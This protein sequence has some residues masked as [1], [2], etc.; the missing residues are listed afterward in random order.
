[1]TR[2]ES[3]WSVLH[4]RN[5][6]QVLQQTTTSR[7]RCAYSGMQDVARACRSSSM[8]LSC[9]PFRTASQESRQSHKL[10]RRCYARDDRCVIGNL[11]M[12][13]LHP[14]SN[15]QAC[16]QHRTN[17]RTHVAGTT[18]LLVSLVGRL[19]D[20]ASVDH[21]L[22]NSCRINPDLNEYTKRRTM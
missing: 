11:K 16:R 13:Q 5:F 7:N 15:Q 17:R 6:S 8:A 1:M 21:H 18:L 4:A 2:R 19:L 12:L 9:L 20:S 3:L 10:I 14:H 22:H